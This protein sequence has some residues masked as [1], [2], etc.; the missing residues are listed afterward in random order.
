MSDSQVPWIK[1]DRLAKLGFGRLG[2]IRYRPCFRYD[3]R[4]RTMKILMTGNEA[5]ARGA[6][7]AGVKFASAYPGTPSTEILEELG[8]YK[9]DV[10]AEWGANEKVAFEAA[11]GAAIAGA[12]AL[13]SMKHVGLNVAADPLFSFAYTGT[14][15]GFVVITA[16]EPGQH[17]S[18]NEQDNRN[19]AVF[20]KV[21]LFEPADSQECHDMVMEAFRVSEEYNT[22]VMMRMTTRTSHS[23]GIV[24]C[25][26]RVE[27]GIREYHKDASRFVGVPANA[28][29]QRVKVEE[30]QNRLK[31]YSEASTLNRIE[32]NG[33][34]IGVIASG[35]AYFF[36][37]EVFGDKASYLKLG[38]T[39]P[40]PSEKI[41]AF[42]SSVKKIYVI[43]E[44]DPILETAVHTLG[45]DCLGKNTFPA[46]GELTSDVIRK[47]VY[48]KTFDKIDT[49][50]A[51][52]VPRAPSLCAG[53][54]HRG[55][56]FELGKR[57][58]IMVSG[59]IGCYTLA[60]GEPYNAMDSAICMGSSISAGHGAQQVFDMRKDGKAPRVVAVLGD[61]T[62][63]H[64]GINSLLNVAYNGSRS[65][66]VILDNRITG[67]TGHQQNPGS[68]FTLQGKSAP[69][70]D[71]A[72]LVKALGI[73]HVRTIDP[74]N[75]K[76][77]RETL[78][79]ALG[80][81]EASV[82]ITRWPCA[83]K[84]FSA[85]D[86]SEFAGAFTGKFQVDP[87]KCIGCKACIR[88]G[89]PALSFDTKTK[90]TSID[91]EVCVGCGVCAQI[92]PKTAIAKV[93]E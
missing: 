78:D 93:E 81:N 31:D 83:L 69:E 28:K 92:C 12:R 14:N 63:F 60:F 27:V 8:S 30:R 43:E 47:A 37:R 76:E 22:P 49:D 2:T 54:P 57:K 62:F 87:E 61:S 41:R 79:W 1:T 74:N 70:I 51:R 58:D 64:T 50:S 34:D 4:S 29:K 56:F 32:E 85:K 82:I 13:A 26:G 3:T 7:E 18:Q 66:N 71:L 17:S 21:P 73:K 40:L 90:K 38:F 5:V 72:A 53:C 33:S 75:L 55:F 35:C 86:R 16:D 80:L 48:G 20:A 45:F 42:C 15:G 89:C 9:D 77:V 52:I 23:K 10:L 46:Y 59:D 67:M 88:S 65:V 6:W 25:A 36:A 19:Y 91:R 84:K 39:Q 24:E 11:M 68:C 44:N